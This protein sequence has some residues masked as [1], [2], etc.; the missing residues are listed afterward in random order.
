MKRSTLS[1]S[2]DIALETRRPL[3]I[4]GAPG[5]GK[6][7][8]VCQAAERHKIE[9]LDWRLVLMDSVDLRGI[10]S[11][12]SDGL[13]RWN[14]PAE[15]PRK[16][17]GI[18]F[19]DEFPQASVQVQNA[20]TQ[21]ILDRKLGSYVLPDG[22]VCIAAGN[23]DSDRAATQRMPS[24]VANRFKHVTLDVDVDEWVEWAE[25]NGID[26]RIVAYHKFR[27]NHLHLFDPKSQEKAFASPRSWEF[28]SDE[29]KAHA[30]LSDALSASE[31]LESF[32]GIVGQIAAT[33]FV[34][35]LRILEK[36]VTVDSILLSPETAALS[37]DAAVTYALVYALLDRADRKTLA[38]IDTYLR[39]IASEWSFAFYKLIERRKPELCK[40]KEFVKWATENQAAL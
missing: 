28:A 6:S 21:L 20:S 17:R 34:G 7:K 8:I 33:D 15:L 2:I 12:T 26:P 19:L 3:F 13:T 30:T 25:E 35:F 1:K 32:A 38:A 22:W 37:E 18:L 10:P 23:R 4:H 31:Q 40:T 11:V 9:C 16:G 5:V 36:L 39:R 27:R 14:P 29:L 24:H